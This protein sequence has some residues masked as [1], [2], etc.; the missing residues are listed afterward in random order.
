MSQQTDVTAVADAVSGIQIDGP[1][2]KDALEQQL[3]DDL[4]LDVEIAGP[5]G[6]T[7]NAAITSVVE[8]ALEPEI[9]EPTATQP[10]PGKDVG[11]FDNSTY[12]AV[13]T[14]DKQP[15]DFLTIAFGGSIKYEADDEDGR[16]LFDALRL[17]KPVELRVA[18]FVA[19]KA[20]AYKENAETGESTVNGKATVKVDSIW[21]L[22]PESL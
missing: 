5:N 13:P 4:G 16:A 12:L 10:A 2:P 17:G 22:S 8:H 15:A 14:I 20:G 9:G 19:A 21:L 6:T 7:G 11:L 18:G 3:T 1:R